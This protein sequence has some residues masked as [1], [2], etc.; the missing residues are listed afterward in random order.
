MSF[1]SSHTKFGTFA[2]VFTP[3][4]ITILGVIM[5][6]RQ[7]WVVGNAGLLGSWLII[8]MCVFIA[9]T[10][11]FS[12]SSIA[13]NTRL[14]AGGAYAIIS[15]SLGLEAGACIGFTLYIAQAFSITM[16]IFGFREGWLS[17]FPN[18]IPIIVDVLTF[19]GVFAIAIFSS[20]LAA[21]V[22]YFVLAV[23]ALSIACVAFGTWNSDPAPIRWWGG[24][25]GTGGG[26]IGFWKTFAVFFPAVTGVM[27]GA[28]MSGDLEDPKKSIPYGTIGALIVCTIIYFYL[29]YIQVQ[30]GSS[31]ELLDNTTIM[32]DQ[33][34]SPTFMKFVILCATS[35]SALATLVGA[36]RILQALAK[37]GSVPKGDFLALL[38]SDGEPRNAIWL[39]GVIAV[40][41]LLFR[42]LNILAPLITIFFLSTYAAVNGVVVVEQGLGLVNFRP[43][44]HLPLWVPLSGSLSSFLAMLIINPA[45]SILSISS[46]LLLYAVLSQNRGE[47]VEEEQGDVRGNIF[48]AL[49]RWFAREAQKLPKSEA[50]AWVPSPLCPIIDEQVCRNALELAGDIAFPRGQVKLLRITKVDSASPQLSSLENYFIQERIR[51][52]STIIQHSEKTTALLCAMQTL[53]GEVFAPNILSLG[54]DDGYLENEILTLTQTAQRV[55]MG[56]ILRCPQQRN[57]GQGGVINIWIRPQKD[58]NIEDAQREGNLDLAIL[59]GFRLAQR[60]KMRLRLITTLSEEKEY[61]EAMNYLHQIIDVARLPNGTDTQTVQ[62]DLFQSVSKAPAAAVNIFGLPNPYQQDFVLQ[63]LD[64]S[65]DACLFVQSSG[66]ESVLV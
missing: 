42:D 7:A 24:F 64:I 56:I 14:H 63:L 13:T 35:S 1:S 39:T 29:S 59:V 36:P 15:R 21:R 37:D 30:M 27:A 10:T 32:I 25:E 48:V 66:N 46:M 61:S 33:S 57:I 8:G 11:A 54:I 60:H 28:N 3:T 2:G 62:G 44:L 41:A 9:S 50:R 47:N 51:F 49:A 31:Q 18:H 12:L 6:L 16:Y 38:S 22:Q 43:R 20:S 40:F 45:I 65:Q 23:T 17:I 53:R 55:G 4:T 58:W 26:Y 34:W 52:A 19:I 5:Y